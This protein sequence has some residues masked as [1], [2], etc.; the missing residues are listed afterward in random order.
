MVGEELVEAL[1]PRGFSER[2]NIWLVT[3]HTSSVPQGSPPGPVLFCEFV[4]IWMQQVNASV[5]SL[6]MP[7]LEVLL[8]L[9][10]ERFCRGIWQIGLN[11]LKWGEI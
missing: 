5:A 7:D 6:L 11:N 10:K 8:D 9:W 4:T 1:S 2:D 3:G